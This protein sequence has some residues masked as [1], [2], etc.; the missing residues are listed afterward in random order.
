[1]NRQT[2]GV[3]ELRQ[4]LSVYLTRVK[5]GTTYSVTEHGQVV[6]LLR[7]AAATD[8]VVERMVAEGRATP[9]RKPLAAVPKA[10]S[11]KLGVPLSREL[12]A[13]REDTI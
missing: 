1:M 5:R 4:N 11:L 9:A 7:P 6:A 10:L 8:D 2:V 3:R 12:D 13:L